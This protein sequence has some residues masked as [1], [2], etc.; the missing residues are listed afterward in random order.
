MTDYPG[1]MGIM[2]WADQQPC[3]TPV[4]K[5]ILYYLAD[6]AASRAICRAD[7]AAMAKFC[8]TTE[9]DCETTLWS[10]QHEKLL[11]GIWLDDVYH[12]AL[13]WWRPQASPTK[14]PRSKAPEDGVREFLHACQDGFC[15]YCG[16]DLREEEKTPHIDHQHPKSRGGSNSVGNLVLACWQC[17]VRKRDKTVGEFRE[18]VIRADQLPDDYRFHGE[19]DT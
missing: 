14:N 1:T 8:C 18:Y 5:L 9:S 2:V 7:M 13:P 12:V 11:Q 19:R 10:M 17:N 3:K 6:H 4:Q 16:G 15:W